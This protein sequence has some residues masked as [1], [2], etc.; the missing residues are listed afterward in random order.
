MAYSQAEIK[1]NQEIAEEAKAAAAA[2]AEMVSQELPKSV[3]RIVRFGGV[4]GIAIPET[5]RISEDFAK[6]TADLF[7]EKLGQ[8]LQA[9]EGRMSQKD[10]LE[11]WK[12]D[13]KGDAVDQLVAEGKE[14]PT[15]D[16][17]DE[18]LDRNLKQVIFDVAKD[19]MQEN[20]VAMMAYNYGVNE[21]EVKII[22][23]EARKIEVGKD[24]VKYIKESNPDLVAEVNNRAADVIQNF[25]SDI[26]IVQPELVGGKT[27]PIPSMA[28]PE[29]PTSQTGPGV[30]TSAQTETPK[31]E[32]VPDRVLSEQSLKDVVEVEQISRVAIGVI[33][34]LP[35][36]VRKQLHIKEKLAEMPEHEGALV[37]FTPDTYK[38][39][40]GLI[41]QLKGGV[42]AKTKLDEGDPWSAELGKEINHI[43]D[44]PQKPASKT[45]LAGG[46]KYLEEM[47]RKQTIDTYILPDGGRQRLVDAL[48][49]LDEA[50]ALVPV[51]MIEQEVKGP[52]VTDPAKPIEEK[53]DQTQQPADDAAKKVTEA[54]KLQKLADD[55]VHDIA[56]RKIEGLLYAVGSSISDIP[57]AE[58]L[59]Y[60]GSAK[61]V[62]LPTMELD[63]VGGKFG[64]KSQDLT[65]K[66]IMTVKTAAGFENANGT[67]TPQIGEG[68]KFQIMMNPNLGF[69]RDKL[70]DDGQG[71][72]PCM[73]VDPVSGQ[74]LKPDTPEYNK[75]K[76]L[77]NVLQQHATSKEPVKPA[78]TDKAATAEY[79]RI[80]KQREFLET[81]YKNELVGIRKA[82]ETFNHLNVLYASGNLMDNKEAQGVN[83]NNIMMD[84]AASFLNQF[85]GIKNALKSFFTTSP[86][87]KMIST[88][89]GTQKGIDVSR[90][91]GEKKDFSDEKLQAKEMQG[92]FDEL[93]GKAAEDLK[94]AGNA[95]A[96]PEEIVAKAKEM[97]NNDMTKGLSG[98]AFRTSMK[99]MFK[100]EDENFIKDTMNT[101][102]D[103]A[104]GAGSKEEAR[105]LFT[106]SIEQ[107]LK[108]KNLGADSVGQSVQ[109]NVKAAEE[110]QKAVKESNALG[111]AVGSQTGVKP[112]DPN[113]E[114]SGSR[115]LGTL[116]QPDQNDPLVVGEN[117][118]VLKH[119]PNTETFDQDP[120][121]L[122]NGRVSGFAEILTKTGNAEALGV[123]KELVDKVNVNGVVPNVATRELT[124]LMEETVILAKVH[125]W[126]NQDPPKDIT[127]ENL[128]A[129]K[130][131]FKIG[132][133]AMLEKNLDSVLA[134]MDSRGE[135]GFDKAD[136]PTFKSAID[137]LANDMRSTK[138]PNDPDQKVS[139][140]DQAFSLHGQVKMDLEALKQ[141]FTVVPLD[142]KLTGKETPQ[143]I[144]EKGNAKGCDFP[145]FY[146]KEGSG[147]VFA[148]IRDKMG[149]ND[150]TNDTFKELEFS[151]YQ[152]QNDINPDD[153]GNAQKLLDNYKFGQEPGEDIKVGK[154]R[155]C[156]VIDEVLKLG[157][158]RLGLNVKQDTEGPKGPTVDEL[159]ANAAKHDHDS[160]NIIPE[161][162]V[163]YPK[164]G[165]IEGLKADISKAL[166]LDGL[167]DDDPV[168]VRAAS[169]NPLAPS[170]MSL[171]AYFD[172][173]CENKVTTYNASPQTGI[174]FLEL[175][176]FDI[177]HN[178][179][180][181][182][183]GIRGKDGNWDFRYV[184]YDKHHVQS[185]DERRGDNMCNDIKKIVDP[186]P[187]SVDANKRPLEHTLYKY[188]QG[189]GGVM[190][191]MHQPI[192]G[193]VGMAAITPGSVVTGFNSVYNCNDRNDVKTYLEHSAANY[194][195]R[196]A[197]QVGAPSD[198]IGNMI[199]QYAGELGHDSS[200]VH[201]GY[202]GSSSVHQH[203]ERRGHF[204]DKSGSEE[205]KPWYRTLVR[206]GKIGESP[207][208][209][210]KR[211][212]GS[213]D[214][215]TQ[216]QT[217]QARRDAEMRQMQSECGCSKE[218]TDQNQRE[219]MNNVERDLREALKAPSV[220]RE[221]ETYVSPGVNI[222]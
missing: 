72:P 166:G 32:T 1:S 106:Q 37:G 186:R 87:G 85:P 26:K 199:K 54:A 130:A 92:N 196:S 218:P 141:A 119:T 198:Q 156:E 69:V 8:R 145:V 34:S 104:M 219:Y 118:L 78:S 25:M 153:F 136:I 61:E 38:T 215:E 172:I 4:Y 220:D 193:L 144:H 14:K 126:K 155:V 77:Y 140:L 43:I 154:E 22:T 181:V 29:A 207:V 19:E 60:V 216:N 90:L 109:M 123:S 142:T 163:D 179:A 183:M 169:L 161:S 57:G 99:I 3:E 137:V 15:Q 194:N 73:G 98:F 184:D 51:N 160:Q 205:E 127:Q 150:P 175:A 213:D 83:Q 112:N 10:A 192:A 27:L 96:T 143:D 67:Y 189:A 13:N 44:N 121:R 138:N 20:L 180:D 178:D 222:K 187:D 214:E 53:K 190:E 58:M 221:I 117:S 162:F 164:I 68:L 80:M 88:V 174:V 120:L 97:A 6:S 52:A 75:Q 159:V 204:N 167:R 82:N 42:G 168:M 152:T 81:T 122:A 5:G 45:D 108:A 84:V 173:K 185:F 24:H 7:M 128:D 65:A 133:G 95:D 36:S 182:I 116:S 12:A 124:A 217:E 139:V 48:N 158:A 171:D 203:S 39:L 131:E 91:W 101:A 76:E 94:K 111:L 202:N 110:T 21:G 2:A 40:T 55:G 49:R 33:N 200:A 46:I 11:S 113:A 134:F 30:K 18:R 59:N 86:I 132:T 105:A 103:S 151:Y 100:G 62:V 188:R 66:L 115:L 107:A 209:K 63:E 16:E 114:L 176:K 89:L 35:D 170:N 212:F 146:M 56:I 71:A 50:G 129:L 31:M 157:P 79:D 211:L 147:S 201:Y 210:L 206:G 28:Q 149:D 41:D 148:A 17:V 177:K 191:P 125:E 208:P 9:I 64:L 102:L 165:K 23:D 93:Y 197:H 70:M 195:L 47:A 74:S 135:H